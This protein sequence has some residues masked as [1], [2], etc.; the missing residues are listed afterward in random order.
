MLID[1]VFNIEFITSNNETK[2]N[3]VLNLRKRKKNIL[4]FQYLTILFFDY[5]TLQPMIRSMPENDK[6]FKI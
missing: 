3:F 2:K 4:S 6:L 1:E 5:I